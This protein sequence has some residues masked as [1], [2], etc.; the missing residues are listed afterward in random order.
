MLPSLHSL[1]ATSEFLEGSQSS[2]SCLSLQTTP[3]S[4][5]GRESWRFEQCSKV[6]ILLLKVS[7]SFI[8]SLAFPSKDSG[9]HPK[10]QGFLLLRKRWWFVLP[11]LFHICF[12]SFSLKSR[13]ETCW[14]PG[15]SLFSC[16]VWRHG[17]RESVHSWILMLSSNLLP[18]DSL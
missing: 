8:F 4:G 14:G 2:G 1:S 7:G 16:R 13:V 15:P 9:N 12:S 11:F 5:S 18:L 17:I 6:C 3:K 10:G